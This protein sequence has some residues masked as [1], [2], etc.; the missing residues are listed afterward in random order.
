MPA[1][2]HRGIDSFLSRERR[3][4]ARFRERR[5]RNGINITLT[6]LFFGLGASFVLRSSHVFQTLYTAFVPARLD[7]F[8]FRRIFR[9]DDE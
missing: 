7:G 8:F 9:G 5:R 4:D 2:P 1:L 6:R 3:V